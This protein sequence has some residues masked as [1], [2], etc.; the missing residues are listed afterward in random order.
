M[1][2]SSSH[3]IRR[4][5]GHG[6]PMTAMTAPL[7]QN[8]TKRRRTFPVAVPHADRRRS[9]RCS[10]GLSSL[11]ACWSTTP[12]AASPM[13]IVAGRPARRSAVKK[14][15][16]PAAT[17]QRRQAEVPAATTGRAIR[18]RRRRTKHTGKSAGQQDHHHHRR[19]DRQRGRRWSFAGPADAPDPTALLPE[20]RSPRHRATAR[21][22]KSPPTAPGPSDV[23][24]R[25]VKAIAGKPNAPRVAI[26]VAGLGIERQRHIR[27]PSPSCRRR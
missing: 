19:H 5:L 20:Q 13:V 11:W 23:F 4:M 12:S 26:V 15:D 25:P 10:P 18:P 6:R 7:G 24:A 8:T 1:L 21:C 16:T 14:P 27:Q 17:G 9:R 2:T 22:R 3:A